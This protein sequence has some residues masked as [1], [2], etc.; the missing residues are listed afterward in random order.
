ML[1]IMEGKKQGL[2][3][4][5]VLLSDVRSAHN[6]GALFRTAEAVGVCEI[7]LAG[8]TPTPVDRFGRLRTDIAKAALGAHISVPWRHVSHAHDEIA[9]LK[10]KGIQSVVLEQTAHSIS[11]TD[12][13]LQS[14]IVL[15][16]G[17]EVEGVPRE[18]C[19]MADVCIEIPMSG[20]KESLN[21]TTAAGVVLFSLRDR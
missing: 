9:R 8:Y 20:T 12:Y 6:V 11:Y 1:A 16:V 15:V 13:V 10:E 18:V 7:I 19:D 4:V 17:N 2:R 14:D 3:A 21:V 5:R